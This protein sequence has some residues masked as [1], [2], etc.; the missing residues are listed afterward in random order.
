MRDVL[1]FPSAVETFG[2]VTLEAMA[3]GLPCVVDE[4]CSGH[5][6]ADGVSGFA[7]ASG[8]VPCVL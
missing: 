8:D 5:L 2:N 6:V 1:L 3:C 4:S 7:I